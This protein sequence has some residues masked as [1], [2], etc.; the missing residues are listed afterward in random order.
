MPESISSGGGGQTFGPNMQIII[1]KIIGGN[2]ESVLVKETKKYQ[3]IGIDPIEEIQE[4]S[5]GEYS[6]DKKDFSNEGMRDRS[7]DS[8][9]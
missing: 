8:K 9:P 4:S 7:I 1:N 3:D 5:L 6:Q 2:S